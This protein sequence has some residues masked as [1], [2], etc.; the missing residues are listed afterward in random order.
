MKQYVNKT[1]DDEAANENESESEKE[2]DDEDEQKE[3]SEDEV[4]DGME[5]QDENN[6]RKEIEGTATFSKLE[7]NNFQENK[8]HVNNW[9]DKNRL[10]SVN[11]KAVKKARKLFPLNREEEERLKYLDYLLGEH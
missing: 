6:D 11:S 2:D 8:N 1:S 3:Y 10:H 7:R 4:E 5:A 9:Q